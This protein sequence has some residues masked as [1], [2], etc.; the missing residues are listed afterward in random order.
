MDLPS[1]NTAAPLLIIV[2][3]TMSAKNRKT[4]GAPAKQKVSTLGFIR[5]NEKQKK[6]NGEPTKRQTSWL[7]NIATRHDL[8]FRRLRNAFVFYQS[9]KSLY[10]FINKDNVTVKRFSRQKPEKLALTSWNCFLKDV[11]EKCKDRFQKKTK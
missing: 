9:N 10:F 4:N 7:N 3:K 2:A 11:E 1:V 6:V 8:E 5:K